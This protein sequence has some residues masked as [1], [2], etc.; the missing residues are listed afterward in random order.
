V[1]AENMNFVKTFNAKKGVP[2]FGVS[3]FSDLT[4][5]EFVSTYLSTLTLEEEPEHVVDY[6]H[7]KNEIPPTLNWVDRGAVGPIGQ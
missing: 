5:E 1:F 2:T 7:M 3:K 4:D 6:T